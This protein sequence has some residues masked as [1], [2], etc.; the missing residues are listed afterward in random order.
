MA[1]QRKPSKPEEFHP[2][3]WVLQQAG[4]RPTLQSDRSLVLQ[5]DLGPVRKVTVSVTFPNG[6]RPSWS[7]RY[8]MRHYD[9]G[10]QIL[11]YYI[12]THGD[13]TEDEQVEAWV[14]E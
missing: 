1:T 12:G 3:P 9:Q 2:V 13:P 4:L 6:R 14:E 10:A 8:V 11:E 7:Y 5:S